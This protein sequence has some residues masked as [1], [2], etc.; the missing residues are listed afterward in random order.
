MPPRATHVHHSADVYGAGTNYATGGSA[1]NGRRDDRVTSALTVLKPP[2]GQRLPVP[3]PPDTDPNFRIDL[4]FDG[5]QIFRV[6]TSFSQFN[7][8]QMLSTFTALMDNASLCLDRYIP[9][10]TVWIDRAYFPLST[11]SKM[12]AL[13][14]IKE[15]ASGYTLAHL[16]VLLLN[17]QSEHWG[18]IRDSP[19]LLSHFKTEAP[20]SH[21]A[22]G[23]LLVA[24]A[25]RRRPHDRSTWCYF[26]QVEVVSL[27]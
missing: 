16:L 3:L 1:G 19:E 8:G 12:M 22:G 23:L 17:M 26:L 21:R 10:P 24:V 6:P 14:E 4:T 11:E 18:T 9:G 13:P 7:N 20:W 27:C 2:G 15:P 25:V 5:G